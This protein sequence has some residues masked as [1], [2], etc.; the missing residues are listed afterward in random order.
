MF[1]NYIF[2]AISTI[3][4]NCTDGEVRLVGG[5]DER[6]GRVEICINNAWGTVCDSLFGV[7]DAGV[8]C[9]QVGGFYRDGECQKQSY[10]FYLDGINM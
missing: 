4:A 3:F 8:V 6:E 1:R 2:V 7:E 9:Q 5:A 10:V